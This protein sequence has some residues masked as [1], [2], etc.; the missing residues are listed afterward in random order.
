MYIVND[1]GC[2]L[3]FQ[4][5]FFNNFQFLDN[6]LLDFIRLS[7][8]LLHNMTDEDLVLSVGGVS[9]S[10]FTC[11]ILGIFIHLRILCKNL[12]KPLS[13]SQEFI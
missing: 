5:V 8:F 12:L 9:A 1:S 10:P 6:F 3:I 13:V 2:I 4:M 11:I 7:L